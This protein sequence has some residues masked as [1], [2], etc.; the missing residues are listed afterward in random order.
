MS[1]LDIEYEL[2]KKYIKGLK[3]IFEKDTDFSYNSSDEDTKVI[4]TTD[5]PEGDTPF[6]TPHIVV[7]GIAYQLNPQNTFNN[8]FYRDVEYNGMANGAQEFAN[9]IPFSL[10]LICLGEWSLSKDLSNRLVQYLSFIA[11]S[12]FYDILGVQVMN[13]SKS[14]TVP[15]SQFPE[16][17]FETSVSIQ[18]NLE[19]AGTKTSDGL[20]A[21]IDTPVTNIN[22][23]Y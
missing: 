18:G 4:I 17:V 20:L 15:Q 7:S 19:W 16:K 12:Y 5:Y 3:A 23:K 22:I 1:I 9:I 10:T 2:E 13:I 11:Y 8:N 6:K 21:G 14:P